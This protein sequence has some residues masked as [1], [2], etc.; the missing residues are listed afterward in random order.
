MGADVG[1]SASVGVS[2]SVGV[3]ASVSVDVR[4]TMCEGVTASDAVP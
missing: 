3:I 4:E 2:V 1:A